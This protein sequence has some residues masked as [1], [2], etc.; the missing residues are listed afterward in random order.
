MA[1]PPSALVAACLVCVVAMLRVSAW[2]PLGADSACR[3]SPAARGL[4]RPQGFLEARL[5]IECPH[6]PPLH[7]SSFPGR[8]AALKTCCPKGSGV[9]GALALI[10]LVLW[11]PKK[12]LCITSL[13]LIFHILKLL[14]NYTNIKGDLGL[15]EKTHLF[16]KISFI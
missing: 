12:T 10:Q 7:W 16:K 13:F 8:K 6:S 1:G 2:Q 5:R 4:H 11:S 9:G 3:L 15:K 14:F